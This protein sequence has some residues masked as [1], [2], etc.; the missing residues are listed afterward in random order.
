MNRESSVDCISWSHQASI[1][2]QFD[3]NASIAIQFDKNSLLDKILVVVGRLER[4]IQRKGPHS[5]DSK[6]HD[7]MDHESS[8]D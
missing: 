6:G 4:R 3:K 1:A 2:I 5:A 7:V 8:G